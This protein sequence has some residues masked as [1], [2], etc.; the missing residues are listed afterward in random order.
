MSSGTLKIVIHQLAARSVISIGYSILWQKCWHIIPSKSRLFIYQKFKWND[1]SIISSFNSNY[2]FFQTKPMGM[3]K[4]KCNNYFI[5]SK[6][7]MYSSIFVRAKEEAN[8]SANVLNISASNLEENIFGKK[9]KLLNGKSHFLVF[10]AILIFRKNCCSLNS[11][12]FDQNT[13]MT[14]YADNKGLV[15]KVS[16]FSWWTDILTFI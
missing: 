9:P 11:T 2:N 5:L 10:V 1:C 4:S 12:L 3:Y 8:M 15:W 16:I 7:F 14:T 13:V 6:N